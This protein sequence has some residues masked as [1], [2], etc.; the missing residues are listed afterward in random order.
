MA[1]LVLVEKEEMLAQQALLDRMDHQDQLDLQDLVEM[2]VHLVPKVPLG[3][4]VMMVLQDQV[5]K[6]DLVD[7][8][9][10]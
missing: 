7:H 8:L 4:L 1:H 5:V 3:H 10:L 2:L 6:G 9:A